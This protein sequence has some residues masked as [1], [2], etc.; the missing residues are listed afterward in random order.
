MDAFISSDDEDEVEGQENEPEEEETEILD[1]NTGIIQTADI[2][3]IAPTA[4]GS[5]PEVVA[6]A[7]LEVPP[8]VPPKDIP[9]LKAKEIP[10]SP[11]KSALKVSSPPP[12]SFVPPPLNL[13]RD[14]VTDSDATS[15][16]TKRSTRSYKS[17]RSYRSTATTETSRLSMVSAARRRSHRASQASL[18]LP[19]KLSAVS[20]DLPPVPNIPKEYHVPAPKPPRSSSY[21]F[22]SFDSHDNAT[23]AIPQSIGLSFQR[24]SS[25]INALH[26]PPRPDSEIRSLQAS[27]GAT[28]LSAVDDLFVMPP[29]SN[30]QSN[31]EIEVVTRTPPYRGSADDLVLAS[32]KEETF[33]SKSHEVSCNAMLNPSKATA[34]IPSIWRYAET[35]RTPAERVEEL[36]QSRGNPMSVQ[37]QRLKSFTKRYSMTLPSVFAKTLNVRSKLAH[38]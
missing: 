16:R 27:A 7:L 14:S 6:P 8:K 18:R 1:E 17:Y 30:M 3:I 5:P 26:S 4:S 13:K 34:E 32:S 22:I 9:F 38:S 33:G 37:F 28:W 35:P 21:S 19:R 11:L 12:S 15:V 24:R 10:I 2:V 23:S 29:K 25:L 36:M 31:N 20:P